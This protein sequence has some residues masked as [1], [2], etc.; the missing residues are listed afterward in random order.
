MVVR[1]NVL[2]VLVGGTGLMAACSS[3][4][5]VSAPNES[6]PA[7]LLAAA[8]NPIPDRYIVVFKSSVGD[9]DRATDDAVRASGAQ[10][11]FRYHTA[12]HG[13]AATIPAAA[14]DGIRRNPNIEYVEADGIGVFPKQVVNDGRDVA[15]A[16]A[17]ARPPQAARARGRTVRSDKR[18]L[19]CHWRACW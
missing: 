15:R 1:R 10:V 13:F 12:L 19:L 9:V 2:A 6:A 16:A 3:E 8:R 4:P 14:L 18:A 11:H 7:P 17:M 5:T